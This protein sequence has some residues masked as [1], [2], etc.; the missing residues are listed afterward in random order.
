MENVTFLSSKLKDDIDRLVVSH[1]ISI[2]LA[3]YV[4][5]MMFIYL[6][7]HTKIIFN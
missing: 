4:F 5:A 6:E 1:C 7:D 3:T 2:L